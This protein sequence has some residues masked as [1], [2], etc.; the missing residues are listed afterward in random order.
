M[1]KTIKKIATF[2]ASQP[3]GVYF[4]NTKQE[5]K[6]FYLDG[7]RKY[8]TW[9]AIASI[10]DWLPVDAKFLQDFRK[11]LD[12]NKVKTKVIF[13]E[14][15]LRFEPKGLKYRQVKVI[16]PSYD[17]QSSIDILEDKILI[18]NPDLNVLGLVVEIE[19]ILD[20]FKDIFDLLWDTLPES[21]KK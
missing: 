21:K 2:A 6:E 7:L 13:K 8:K 5:L 14:S 1:E 12:K 4:L 20:I 15:G 17:F 3:H 9:N 11:E 18:M 16:P 19:S 10:E